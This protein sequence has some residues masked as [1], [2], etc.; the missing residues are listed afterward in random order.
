VPS[1]LS[2][3]GW[4]HNFFEKVPLTWLFLGTTV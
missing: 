4:R 3:P 2:G 1:Q